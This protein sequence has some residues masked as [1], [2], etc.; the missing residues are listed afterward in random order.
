MTP[1]IQEN[2]DL[3]L[4]V[5]NK[6]HS[7]C[8]WTA[9]WRG[10]AGE[11][12]KRPGHGSF[13]PCVELRCTTLLAHKCGPPAWSSPKPVPWDSHRSFLNHGRHDQPWTELSTPLFSLMMGRSLKVP[14]FLSWFDLFGHQPAYRRPPRVSSLIRKILCDSGIWARNQRQRT[15]IY[16]YYYV[17]LLKDQYCWLIWTQRIQRMQST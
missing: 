1:R 10:A 12:Q 9:T 11:V 15:D 5:Y 3:H 4:L 17:T 14:R 7:G 8:R 16:I 6:Y 2:N 13:Y